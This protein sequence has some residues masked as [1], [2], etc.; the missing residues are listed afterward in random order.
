MSTPQPGILPPVPRLARYLSFRLPI[1]PRPRETAEALA[2]LRVNESLVIGLGESTIDLLDG[3]I[4]GL[5]AFPNHADSKHPM[6]STLGA[7][8]IWLRGD[9]RGELVNESRRVR[10]ALAAGFVLDS[11]IDAFQYRDSRDLTG[12]IDGTENPE[13]DAAIHAAFAT[14]PLAGSSF[15]AVQQWVHDLSH[16]ES[17]PSAHQDH[18]I[19]RRKSDNEELADAPDSAHVKRTAQESFDPEA[20]VLRRSMPW[21]DATSAGLVFVAFGRTLDAF[22]AQLRRMVGLDD[23]VPDALF[24]FSEPMTG[25]YYWCPPVVGHKL[26]L[27]ALGL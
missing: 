14:G 21:A 1:G 9:D 26:D 27:G 2:A 4:D 18:I 20:F 25:S 10:G 24:Q 3:K 22:E 17:L 12:Y 13:G 15:V 5:H 23:G 8:W 11:V 6:P 16:F 7:L 19:G